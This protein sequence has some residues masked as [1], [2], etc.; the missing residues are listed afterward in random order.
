M[1]KARH[2][3]KERIMSVGKC[4]TGRRLLALFARCENPTQV[5]ERN[6]LG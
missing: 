3:H 1:N 6:E 2:N 5:L 4:T